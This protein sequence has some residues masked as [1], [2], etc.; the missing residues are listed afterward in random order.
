MTILYHEIK[1]NWRTLL[2]W[3]LSIGIFSCACILLFDNVADGMKDVATSFSKMRSFSTAFGMN[4]L[5]ISTLNGYYATQIAMI[6]AIGGAMFAGMTGALMLSKEEE[7]HTAEFL[8]TLPL[9]RTSIVVKKYFSLFI[10][11]ALFNV[12]VMGLDLLALVYLGKSFDFDAYYIYHLFAFLMQF[13]I[14]SICFMISAISK[15]K[16]IGLALG[17]AIMAYLLDVMCRII[18]KIKFVKYVTPFYYSNASDIFVKT[19]P[20][21]IHI[22]IACLVIICTFIIS[23]LINQSRDISS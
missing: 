1:S 3:S 4:K 8:Y 2:I 18:S 11:V 21:A 23:L 10:L 15:R 13:E 9:S 14:A 7:G 6:V 20:A 5:N 16:P 19:K 22:I 12:I 17:I